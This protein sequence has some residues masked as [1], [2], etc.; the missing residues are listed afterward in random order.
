M[1]VRPSGPTLADVRLLPI[2]RRWLGTVF[3]TILPADADERLEMGARDVPM[4]QF[5]DDLALYA[6]THFNAGLRASLWLLVLLLPLVVLGRLATF[7]GLAPDERLELLER[8]G[9]SDVYLL[10]ELPT[11]FKTIA[12]LGFCG[13]PEVQQ[14]IGIAPTDDEPPPWAHGTPMP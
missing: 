10:R 11:L 3:D 8:L 4:E 9:R 6:P 2:E 13:L 7:S 5:A 12:C 14:S 1:K